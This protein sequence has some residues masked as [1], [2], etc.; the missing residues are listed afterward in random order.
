MPKYA[1]I[2]NGN[3]IQVVDQNPA[4]IFHPDI[5]VNF[6]EVPEE[7]ETNYLYDEV[8]DTFS[9]PPPL[10]EITPPPAAVETS[11]MLDAIGFLDLF[12]MQEE[13]AIRQARAAGDLVVE[14]FMDRLDKAQRI[15]LD[16]P[17]VIA[18]VDYLVTATL[19][20]AERRDEILAGQA[21]TTPI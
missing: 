6:V 9:P 15:H 10:L 13:L 11:I 2:V 18:G 14:S 17:R 12:T 8:T 19:I 3:V 21:P 20:T 1:Q 16:D 7:V 4:D 5:A